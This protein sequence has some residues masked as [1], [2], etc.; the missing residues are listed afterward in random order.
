MNTYKEIDRDVIVKSLM[1]LV[2]RDASSGEI[3]RAIDVYRGKANKYVDLHDLVLSEVSH[4]MDVDKKRILGGSRKREIVNARKITLKI[5][6]DL[7]DRDYTLTRL[8]FIFNY[9]DHST[10]RHNIIDCAKLIE[11]DKFFRANYINIK[12]RVQNI[13]F[14]QSEEYL[15]TCI[16]K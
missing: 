15:K 8:G 14:E 16:N 3:I 13:M 1:A 6:K 2:D 7:A 11:S 10:I 9:R 12:T 5:I 4:V